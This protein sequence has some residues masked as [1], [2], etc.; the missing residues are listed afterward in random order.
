M[1]Y[2]GRQKHPHGGVTAL[3]RR[4]PALRRAPARL[5]SGASLPA[6]VPGP[7]GVLLAACPLL[8]HHFITFPKEAPT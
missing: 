1:L 5:A 7:V 2:G 6:G 3:D 8:L 4:Q